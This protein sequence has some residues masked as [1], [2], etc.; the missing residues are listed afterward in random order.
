MSAITATLIRIVLIPL[1]LCAMLA[2]S[3]FADEDCD[4][5]SWLMDFRQEAEAAGISESTLDAALNDI[6]P[7][8]KVIDLDQ[9]QPEF[10]RTFWDYLDHRVTPETVAQGRRLLRKNHRLLTRLDK[11]YSV[12]PYIIV[13]LWGVETRF[14]EYMGHYPEVAALATLAYDT[15]RS[16]FFRNELMEA[17]RILD[18]GHIKPDEM[19]GSWAG[20]MGHMQFMPSTF[21]RYAVDANHDGRKDIWNTLSDALASASNYVH[22]IGWKH[23]EIWGREVKLPA[24]FDWSLTRPDVKKTVKA[25]AALGVRNA[26]GKPLPRS[27]LQARVILPQGHEGPAFLVYRNFDAIM[28]WNHSLNYALTVGILADQL[29]GLPPPRLGRDADN[30]PLSRDEIVEMQQRLNLAGCDAG[31]PDGVIGTSTRSAA[32]ACQKALGI[33]ADSYPSHSLLD[34]L[35]VRTSALTEAEAPVNSN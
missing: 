15:R 12:P 22:R 23:G 1:S 29:V 31:E 27:S 6:E 2:G 5:Q 14:G 9:S 10:A 11:R 13:A 21:S 30:Q 19:T 28:Q 20:A 24:G 34:C 8:A 7:M 18:E 25:W 35:R 4:F 26:D 3:A 33:P 17:L 16:S 32:F